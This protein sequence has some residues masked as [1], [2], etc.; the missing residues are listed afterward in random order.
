MHNLLKK[1]TFRYCRAVG[2]SCGRAVK[3]NLVLKWVSPYHIPRTPY[4]LQTV[5]ESEHEIEHL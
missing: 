4:Q 2:Q 1:L 3:K 5:A